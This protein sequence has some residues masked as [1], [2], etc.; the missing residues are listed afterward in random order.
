MGNKYFSG[1][2]Y[3]LGNEDTSV[4]IELVKRFQPKAIFSICGSGGRALPLLHEDCQ[5]LALTD[6]SHEQL[7][8]AE[9]RLATYKQ[10]TFLDFSLFWGYFPFSDISHHSKRRELFLTLE[11]SPKT[12]AFISQVF[13]EI[14]Y[15]SLLYLGKW[16]Q[17]FNT[18]SK[19]NRFVLGS[20]YDRMLRF[21]SLEDQK[22]YYKNEFPINKW[23]GIIHLLGNKTMFNALLYKGDFIKKNSPLSHFDY[24]FNAFERLFT[25]DLAQKSFFLHL[26]FYGKIHSYEGVPIEAQEESF[27]RIKKSQAKVHYFQ[28]DFV[29]HLSSG[30]CK[31]DF[32]SLSDVPSYFQ[33]DLELEFMQKIKPGLHPGA[34]I[35]N[36]YYLRTSQCL[37]NG[38]VD[39]TNEYLNLLEIEKVQ[40]YEIKIYKYQP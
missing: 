18:F 20:D 35:V 7:M 22:Y 1:L 23:K 21:D 9:L 28:E 24:Y 40:M 13:H 33:G 29:N 30:K 34:L 19:I 26:C 2:N 37:L 10:L 8:L 32:L 3:T 25:K 15:Q 14:K 39:V 17:T 38:Y 11:I 31:Y 36:R 5:E 4:E 16:E 6:L 27:E 12:Y